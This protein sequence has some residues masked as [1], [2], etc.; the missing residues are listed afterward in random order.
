MAMLDSVSAEKTCLVSM[1]SGR[2]TLIDETGGRCT[3][4]CVLEIINGKEWIVFYDQ[5]QRMALMATNDIPASFNGNARFNISNAMHA[6]AAALLAGID[7]NSIRSAM[8]DFRAGYDST[9]GRR[10]VFDGL[11]FRVLMD[12]AHNADGFRNVTEFVDSQSVEGRKILM[13]GFSGDR[14][15]ANVRTAV[16]Q[17]AGH[18]DHFVCRNFRIPRNDRQ[19]HEIPALL[20]SGLI[21]AGVAESAI[22]IVPDADKA[23]RHSLAMGAPGDLVVLLVGAVE[24]QSVWDLLNESAT[25]G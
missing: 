11:P 15:D 12:Y 17:L 7:M 13:V 5:E 10:N 2:D 21:A 23:V 20:K 25:G 4:C 3:N 24:F 9:P 8:Q 19:A 18:F 6:I 14:L 1:K 22:S 16:T